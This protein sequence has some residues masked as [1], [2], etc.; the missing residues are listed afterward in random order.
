MTTE[1]VRTCEISVN[2][3]VTARRY[4]P[5]DSKLHTRRRENLKSHIIP[6][7]TEEYYTDTTLIPSNK[8]ILPILNL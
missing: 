2:F 7:L 1:A 6:K 8:F 3:N 5:E 4:I